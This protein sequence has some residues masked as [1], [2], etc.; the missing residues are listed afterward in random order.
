MRGQ[1][2]PSKPLKLETPVGTFWGGDV[3]EGFS[4]DAEFLGRAKGEPV[5]L[6]NEF[7]RLC[8]LDNAYIFDLK[9]IDDVKIP[10]MS[11]ERFDE[12]INTE[13]KRGKSCD[14]YQLTIE[15]IQECGKEA[16]L[17]IL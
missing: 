3:L 15:Q 11:V 12:I 4:A 6:D 8:K 13:M 1:K 14:Y 2:P 17:R 5:M 16:K 9:D 10:P 7:Y